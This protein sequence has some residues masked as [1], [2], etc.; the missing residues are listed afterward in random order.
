MNTRERK[1][2]K[3]ETELIQWVNRIAD[4]ERDMGKDLFAEYHS[5]GA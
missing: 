2:A 4:R 3:D 5:G 1:R